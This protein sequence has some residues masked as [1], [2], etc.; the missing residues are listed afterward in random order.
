MKYN[1]H[2][3][4]SLAIRWIFVHTIGILRITGLHHCELFESQKLF[5]RF[6]VKTGGRVK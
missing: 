5:K 3:I 6:A 1:G 4:D 2:V